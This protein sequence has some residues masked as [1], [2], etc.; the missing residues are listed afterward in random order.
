MLSKKE[1]S[2][3][4]YNKHKQKIAKKASEKYSLNKEEYLMKQQEYKL[5]N[6]DKI[7][8]STKN[9]RISNKEKRKEQQKRYRKS[10]KKLIQEKLNKRRLEDINYRITTNLRSRLSKAIKLNYK[11]GSAVKDLGCSVEKFKLWIEMQWQEGMNWDNWTKDGWHLDHIIP[12]CKFNLENREELLKACHYTN[13]QPMWA[14]EN[15]TKGGR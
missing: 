2:K 15:L 8:E 4:Y 3:R 10:H 9:Y 7:K 1:I 6:K 14:E 13:I 5:K 11:R 12:L